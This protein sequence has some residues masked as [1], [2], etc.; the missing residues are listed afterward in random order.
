MKRLV[1]HFQRSFEL[2]VDNLEDNLPPREIGDCYCAA[3]ELPEPRQSRVVSLLE[4]V[5]NDDF[6]SLPRKLQAVALFQRQKE[7]GVTQKDISFVIGV[8]PSTICKYKYDFLEHPENLFPP[9][10]KPSIIRKVFLTLKR[11]FANSGRRGEAFLLECSLSSSPTSTASSSQES[12][13][14][15]T[16]WRMATPT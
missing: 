4:T 14:G 7:F 8:A 9:R 6:W 5:D 3:Y 16:W 11:S 1:E 2:M 15:S 10:G 13:S 12:A